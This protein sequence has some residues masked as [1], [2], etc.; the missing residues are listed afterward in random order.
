MAQTRKS[1][2]SYEVERE[3]GEGG[4]GVVHLAVQPE[5]ERRVV[6]KTIRRS[7]SDDA[8]LVERF[9]REARAAAAVHHQNVV[10]VYDC[11]TWRGERYIA[12]EFVDG[13]N[14]GQ[15]LERTGPMTPR[16]AALVTLEL[17]RGL[18]EIHAHGIVHRDLKPS[19]VLLGRRG[20][21]KIADFGIA[22]PAKGRSL[23]ATG[24]AVGTPAYMSPE[25]H[26]AERPDA[27]SDLYAVGAMLYE[28]LTGAPPFPVPDEEGTEGRPEDEPLL[29]RIESGRYARARRAR[30]GVPRWLDAL[31]H[32]CLRPR[33]KRRP[34][35]A[36]AVRE[37]LERRLG[38]PSPAACRA[39]IA[40][41]LWEHKAFRGKP[42]ETVFARRAGR[43]V[44]IRVRRLG[45][46]AAA[47]ATGLL[48][49]SVGAVRIEHALDQLTH[50][51]AVGAPSQ[52]SDPP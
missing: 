6:L 20:E 42:D 48:A 23:T 12:Q 32:R 5:L 29:T 24:Y 51:F 39:E 38:A 14:L 43:R 3:L 40:A 49:A 35:S 34:E 30:P 41:W 44:H 50:V 19:N 16:V 22:L 13:D 27:R 10:C 31:V 46:V 28:M 7:L 15:A 25:Q 33:P 52:L 21:A 45:W 26:R 8:T 2:A 9:V 36:A 37:T 47:A 11:I 4:M 17:V 18:E 1:I